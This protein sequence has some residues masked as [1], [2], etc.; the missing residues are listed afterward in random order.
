[1]DWGHRVY[2]F[3]SDPKN[4]K[5]NFIEAKKLGANF[6]I[7]KFT[8]ENEYLENIKTIQGIETLYLYK[9]N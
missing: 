3:V 2:A 1:M 9:I 8:I 6:V 7:S 5:I 4:I